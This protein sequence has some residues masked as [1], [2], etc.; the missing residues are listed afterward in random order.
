MSRGY[1]KAVAFQ[2]LMDF[3]KKGFFIVALPAAGSCTIAAFKQAVRLGGH[4]RKL[5]PRSLNPVVY[6]LSR[7]PECLGWG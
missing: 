5:F 4:P 6:N 3:T 2:P 1:Y 7:F